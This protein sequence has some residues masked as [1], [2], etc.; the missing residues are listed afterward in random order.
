MVEDLDYFFMT[1]IHIGTFSNIRESC[2]YKSTT[3]SRL[4]LLNRPYLCIQ[5]RDFEVILVAKRL[6]IFCF[7]I[8]ATFEL[9][10]E[11]FGGW[12]DFISQSYGS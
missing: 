7:F 11:Q 5:F 1:H 9:K 12:L 6:K 8:D 3:M 10:Q 2:I 4:T